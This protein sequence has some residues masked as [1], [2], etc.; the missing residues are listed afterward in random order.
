LFP[1][2]IREVSLG[3]TRVSG[4]PVVK[5]VTPGYGPVLRPAVRV[6]QELSEWHVVAIAG[7]EIL[8]RSK[9][10]VPGSLCQQTCTG[11]IP[12]IYDFQRIDRFL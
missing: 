10:E 6:Q 1:V 4:T 9:E 5:R 11:I 8:L 2:P 3:L 7:D 12:S